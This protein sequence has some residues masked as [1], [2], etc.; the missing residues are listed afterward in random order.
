MKKIVLLAV[1]ALMLFASDVFANGRGFRSVNIR[2]RSVETFRSVQFRQS[3]R[4]NFVHFRS[5]A[6]VVPVASYSYAAAFVQPVYVQ[7]IVAPVYAP[8][9]YAAPVVQSYAVAPVYAPVCGFSAG[10]SAFSNYGVSFASYG[11]GFADHFAAFNVGRRAF[12][13]DRFSSSFSI[14]TRGVAIRI[15]R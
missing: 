12:F 9:A 5:A 2:V 4:S 14:R 1:L 15:R 11:V 6:F 7:P 10:Y 13:G 8:I 3:F